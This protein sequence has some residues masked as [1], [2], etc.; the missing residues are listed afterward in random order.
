[1][2]KLRTLQNY[3]QQ[4]STFYLLPLFGFTLIISILFFISTAFASMSTVIVDNTDPEFS[5]VGKWKTAKKY[6]GFYGKNYRI[7]EKGDG[8][9]SG[10]W[11]FTINESG[12][13]SV[14]A[15]WAGHNKCAPDAPYT[16]YNN[17][18]VQDTVS[19]DQSKDS[20]QFNLLGTFWLNDGIL[21]VVLTNGASGKVVADAIMVEFAGDEIGDLD[22]DPDSSVYYVSI[23]NGDDANSG[24]SQ[25][26]AWG[27]IKKAANTLQAGETVY[28]MAGTY[29]EVICPQNSGSADNYITYA[30]FGDDIVVVDGTGISGEWTL[31]AIIN[32]SYIRIKDLIVEQS[33]GAGIWIEDSNSVVI[34]N[35][36]TYHTHNSGIFVYTSSD[37]CL[38]NNKVQ[39]ACDGGWGECISIFGTSNFIVSN[40]EVFE[41]GDTSGGGEGIDACFSSNGKI[42]DNVVHDLDELGIYIDSYGYSHDIE[43]YGNNVER[44]TTGIAVSSESGET[45]ENIFIYQNIIKNCSWMG[46][47]ISN[48]HANGLRKNI[49]IT[50][51]E[52]YE[53][54]LYTSA[55]SELFIE[56][57]ANV[58]D[59]YINGN[60]Y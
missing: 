52:I 48:W 45:V 53:S 21:E 1:M 56:E 19:M 41:S 35:N 30:A 43:V 17:D 3:K 13:Y 60:V 46:L 22:T 33:E 12:E 27:T 16:I 20:G 24:K 34:E 36:W 51:N 47:V 44:C 49:Q 54:P 38:N 6:S 5:K 50:N 42:F 58:E 32:E 28:I 7:A 39:L 15:Q 37:I 40:N 29:N 11:T 26:E 25:E 55:N 59:I 2:L 10:T 8:S 57:G 4:N 9:S 23:Q 31:I 14:Y 18:V